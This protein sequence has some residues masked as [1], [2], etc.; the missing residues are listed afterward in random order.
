MPR[1]P[2]PMTAE[3]VLVVDDERDMAESCAYFLRRAGLE[4]KLAF[5]GDEALEELD[6]HRFALV[7]TDLRMPRMTGLSLLDAVRS[8]PGDTEVL[9]ITG[10]PDIKTAVE[11]IKRGAF[12][13]IP[14]PFDEAELMGRVE[15]ALA[16]RRLK[17]DNTELRERLQ[18]GATRQLVYR[19]P[20]FDRVVDEL[21]RAARTDAT[22]LLLGESGTGKELLAHFLH[23][24]SDRTGR[25]FIPLDCATVPEHLVE[26][27]LFGHVKGA[28]TGANRDKVG[29]FQIADGGTLFLDEVGELPLT[30]QPKLLRALQERQVRPVGAAEV[31]AVDVRLVCAT[32]RDLG[33]EVRAGR[34]REDLYYR[35][36]VVRVEVP[37]L[38]ERAE[39]VPL[40]AEHFRADF[41]AKNPSCR[42]R[43]FAPAALEV[44]SAYRW[45]GNV[46]QLGNAIARACALANEEEI[47]VDDLTD[48]VVGRRSGSV[49]PRGEREPETFQEMKSR[50]VAAIES[51]YLEDLLR[52]F[53]GNVTRSSAAAGMTR[54]AFQKLMQKHGIRSSSYRG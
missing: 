22:V 28:F 4:V 18:E 41:A 46:R 39:D 19:S 50:R 1:L 24:A 40:L 13:Y 5:S 26:S 9:L 3:L 12:D 35:M 31:R 6:R 11:A 51:A 37:P 2:Q 14:K 30:L 23:E 27:E 44:L 10:Y 20:R 17:E 16:H 45:P 8:R 42:V 54:S 48:E 34:F 29:M 32:H 43:G 25:P 33:E 38:R 36:D 53:G 15:K 21:R 7:I 47:G 49:E 52:Q